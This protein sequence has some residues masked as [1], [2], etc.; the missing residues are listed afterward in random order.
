MKSTFLSFLLAGS[1]L[2]FPWMRPGEAPDEFTQNAKRG[3]QAMK[4]DP[5]LVALIQQ[6]HAMQV[7]EKEEFMTRRS[8]E[9]T[10]D[11][12]DV[13]NIEKRATKT[14]CLSHPLGDFFPTNITGLKKF[15]EP[16]YPYQDPIASDQRGPCPGM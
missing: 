3:L 14:N 6:L 10:E 9:P 2:A 11:M 16:G 8:P 7:A 4:R 1:A 15:P 5:E 12:L 13:D